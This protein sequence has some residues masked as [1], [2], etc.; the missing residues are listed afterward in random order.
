M[1]NCTSRL[2]DY[3]SEVKNALGGLSG[4]AGIMEMSGLE[5]SATG[6]TQNETQRTRN[7]G[8][9]EEYRAAEEP[10]HTA[11]YMLRL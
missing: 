4:R 7:T 10:T 6:S 5:D 9:W 1:P 3:R 8:K 11:Q 2:V